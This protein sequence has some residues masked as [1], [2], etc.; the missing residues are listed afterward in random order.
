MLLAHD[1][2]AFNRWEAG[3]RLGLNRLL[4]ALGS[5]APV[6][7][8]DRLRR[9]DAQRAS[10]PRSGPGLQGA[11]TGAAERALPGRAARRGRP[12]AHP[13]RART[14][15]GRSWP[16]C[17]TTTGARPGRT[18]RCAKA[19]TLVTARP[20]AVRW[21]TARWPCW[22]GTR[23]AKAARSGPAAPTSCVKDAS[24]M[25]RPPGRAAGPGVGPL[26]AGRRGA[27]ALP[28]AVPRR[29]AGHRQ[30][31]HRAGARARA[32]GPGR[33]RRQPACWPAP[34]SC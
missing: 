23:C 10:R 16:R 14:G 29:P 28:R 27:G 15:A 18:T 24:D 8:D 32:P 9:R 31:V 21:P 7:L 33:Q 26:A 1:R 13:H 2:D 6:S 4:A 25:T 19:T 5:D 34:V 12:A 17:C 11:G 20:A 3:Q 22:C 30:V